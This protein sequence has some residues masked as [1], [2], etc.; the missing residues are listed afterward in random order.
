MSA[1][2]NS[3]FTTTQAGWVALVFFGAWLAFLF[4]PVGREAKPPPAHSQT[5]LDGEEE[6]RAAGLPYNADWIGLPT[7]FKAWA[8]RLSWADGAL[9]FS[10]WNP[11]TRNYTYRFEATRT[12]QGYRFHQL[13]ET[14]GQEAH[15][16]LAEGEMLP[17][18]PFDFAEQVPV[19]TPVR[20]VPNLPGSDPVPPASPAEKPKVDVQF[21]PAPLKVPK[22]EL[23]TTDVGKN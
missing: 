12:T 16:S 18:H 19:E 15:E 21:S 17:T 9:R 13:A 23:K 5:L 7:Y 10:Y 8:E 6:L 1:R 11:G 2:P 3:R 22:P 14:P 4:L 20:P